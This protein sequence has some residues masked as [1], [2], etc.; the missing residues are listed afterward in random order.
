MGRRKPK[1]LALFA[2]PGAPKLPRPPAVK[3]AHIA[4]AGHGGRAMFR[5]KRCGWTSGWHH[6]LTVK[7]IRRGIECERCPPNAQKS[8]PPDPEVQRRAR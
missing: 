4:D 3:R 1:Q 8:P 7:E 2:Q 6:G 5:C